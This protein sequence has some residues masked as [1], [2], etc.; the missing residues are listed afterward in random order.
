MKKDVIEIFKNQKG[1]LIP[2]H[3]IKLSIPF[4]SPYEWIFKIESVLTPRKIKSIFK[5]R[6]GW[7]LS[8]CRIRIINPTYYVNMDITDISFSDAPEELVMATDLSA[9][10]NFVKPKKLYDLPKIE[11]CLE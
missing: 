8:L 2:S 4:H 11:V 10:L 6:A 5:I 9:Y 1:L 7:D 3:R